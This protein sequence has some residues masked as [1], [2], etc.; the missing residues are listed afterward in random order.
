MKKVLAA[1]Q[2]WAHRSVGI[3]FDAL[4][5][6]ETSAIVPPGSLGVTSP[7]KDCGVAYDPSPWRILRRTLRLA[8]MPRPDGFT[9]VDIGCGKGKVLLSAMTL[10]FKR[11]IGIDFSPYL[12]D[13]ACKNLYSARLLY[14]NCRDVKV[15]CMDAAEWEPP[16]EPLMLFFY[17]PFHEKVMAKVIENLVSS[18]SR[19]PR[20]M[21]VVF[22]KSSFAGAILERTLSQIDQSLDVSRASRRLGNDRVRIY[23]LPAPDREAGARQQDDQF[24][25]PANIGQLFAH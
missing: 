22:F 23:C 21:F 10:P 5:G 12:C 11:L 19:N 3:A 24:R 2:W 20:P 8:D 7:N 6:V 15:I 16:N 4:H 1:L 25:D 9:F 14:R 18:Y 13:I 17:N